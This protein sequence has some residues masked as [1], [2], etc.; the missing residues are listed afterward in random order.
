[1]LEIYPAPEVK[2]RIYIFLSTEHTFFE[3]H[4]VHKAIGAVEQSTV[5][6]R[7][8]IA[9]YNQ[10]VLHFSKISY[11]PSDM[12]VS[13]TYGLD[14]YQNGPGPVNVFMPLNF[15]LRGISSE[16]WEGIAKLQSPHVC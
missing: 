12:Y 7:K 6:R 9:T 3:Q 8:N 1:M 5:H 4:S 2:L 10:I 16:V 11:M 15:S 13:C 14:T